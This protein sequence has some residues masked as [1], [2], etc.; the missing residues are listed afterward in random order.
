[1][2]Y[3]FKK[4]T[5]CLTLQISKAQNKLPEMW[6]WIYWLT[7]QDITRKT[8][9]GHYE[10]ITF[11][12]AINN[13]QLH[14]Q[15]VFFHLNTSIEPR[16]QVSHL[17]IRRSGAHSHVRRIALNSFLVPFGSNTKPCRRA[18]LDQKMCRMNLTTGHPLQFWSKNLYKAGTEVL[19]LHQ[20]LYQ[21]ELLIIML[22]KW[23]RFFIIISFYINFLW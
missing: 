13:D 16:W 20:W 14:W 22:S 19:D 18:E 5:K 12:D 4:Q 15:N 8:P 6:M 7:L 23:Q 2:N 21:C 1:M 10:W 3:S 11:F 9:G 17:S